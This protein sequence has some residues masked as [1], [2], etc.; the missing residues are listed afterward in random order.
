M[1]RFLLLVAC[2]I[3]FL[4]GCN[5]GP[6]TA[7][8]TPDD[9][10]GDQGPV[11]SGVIG[12]YTFTGNDGYF[13]AGKLV[14]DHEGNITMVSDD[15]SASVY[16]NW[17][18]AIW[19]EYLNPRGYTN[20]GLPYYYLGDTFYYDLWIDY[21]RGIPMNWYPLLYSKLTTEQR[22]YPSMALMPGD[23]VEVWDPFEIAPFELKKV[24]DSYYIP[25]GAVPGNNATWVK[26]DMQFFFGCF[27]FCLAQGVCGLWDP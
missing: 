18:F 2:G 11:L 25:K 15:R 26:I 1:N 4:A 3:F 5:S 27:E 10:F 24:T 9:V 12:E 17:W 8:V 23:S 20:M 16:T 14:S 21:K 7:N 22:Y 19:V 6:T 13:E